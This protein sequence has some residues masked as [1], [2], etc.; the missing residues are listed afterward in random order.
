MIGLLYLWIFLLTK[1]RICISN[2]FCNYIQYTV[3]RE[4]NGRFT[5]DF[6]KLYAKLFLRIPHK[7]MVI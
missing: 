1:Q 7:F 3:W 5:G 2:M 6:K 4:R